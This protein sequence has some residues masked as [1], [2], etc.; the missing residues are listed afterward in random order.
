MG[1]D[2]EENE[3]KNDAHLNKYGKWV[4]DGTNYFNNSP[5]F[6]CGSYSLIQRLHAPGFEVESFSKPEISLCG[7]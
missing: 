2:D 7:F 1:C 6:S 3:K 4:G 5:E